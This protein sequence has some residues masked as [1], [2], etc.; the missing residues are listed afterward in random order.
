[1]LKL[2]PLL[3]GVVSLAACSPEQENAAATQVDSQVESHEQALT[4]VSALVQ[5]KIVAPEGELIS[6]AQFTFAKHDLNQDGNQEYLVLMSDPYFC[7]SGGCNLYI[8]DDQGNELNYFTVAKSP[9]SVGKQG[10]SGWAD[11]VMYSNGA[12][13]L[14]VHDGQHYPTNPSVEPEATDATVTEL[15]PRDYEMYGKSSLQE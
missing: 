3:L 2:I 14:M 12:N 11:L 15:I 7:G 13:R 1:M 5:D 8:F 10:E 4:F 9:V 6:H